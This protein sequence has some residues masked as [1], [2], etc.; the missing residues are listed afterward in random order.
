MQ[1]STCADDLQYAQKLLDLAGVPCTSTVPA[2]RSAETIAAAARDYGCS[3]IAFG[4]DASG[5]AGTIFGSPAQQVR[6][7]LGASGDAQVIVC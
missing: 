1:L 4:R 3:R 6:Q 5:L 2:G 7:H